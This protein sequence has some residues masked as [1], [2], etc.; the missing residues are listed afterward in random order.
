VLAA[1]YSK[2]IVSS[3]L[4]GGLIWYGLLVAAR[5]GLGTEGVAAKDLKR[6]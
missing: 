5:A 4:F 3:L 1:F 2:V 6:A